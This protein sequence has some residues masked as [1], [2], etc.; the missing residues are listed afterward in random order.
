MFR[1]PYRSPHRPGK[2]KQTFHRHDPFVPVGNAK[3]IHQEQ[4]VER[5]N[6]SQMQ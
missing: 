2:L 6:A 1:N 4:A 5:M 3:V